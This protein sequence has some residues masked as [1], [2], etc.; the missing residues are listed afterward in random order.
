MS[1]TGSASM[2]MAFASPVLRFQIPNSEALNA[3]LVEESLA[4]REQSAGMKRSNR[5]GWHS[6]TDLMERTEPGLSKL[7][8][9][10][11]NCTNSASKAIAPQFDASK[12]K[13]VASGWINI[14]P[15]HG[16]N[17]PHRHIGA[18][19]SGCYYVTVPKADDGPS[20]SIE[21]V[22]PVVVPRELKVFNATCYKD[23]L[24]MKPK[25][26]DLLMFPSYL[27]HWVYPNEIDEERIT[28]A[29]NANYVPNKPE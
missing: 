3:T 2:T 6:D 21:F 20:G 10:I 18:G 17:V 14:N 1:E 22:S 9:I 23:N 11:R 4:M 25:A 15:Q 24:T 7:A 27:M 13:L 5:Q 16:Y 8:S 26:G 12:H 28:I 29:F 19:W